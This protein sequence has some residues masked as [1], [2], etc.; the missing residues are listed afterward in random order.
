MG[1]ATPW[2]I[3]LCK[4][5]DDKRGFV[6]VDLQNTKDMFVGS[7]TENIAAYWQDVSYGSMDFSGS[8]AFGWL[9]LDKNQSDYVGSGR[10]PQG[11]QD[12]VTWARDAAKDAGYD[13][14]SFYGVAV[15]MS[16]AT[17]LWGGPNNV[18]CDLD[19]AMAAILQ[20]FGHGYGLAKHTRAVSTPTTDYT[21]PICVMS[22]M[23]FGGSDP[24][25]SGPFGASGPLLCSPYVDIAGWLAPNR[26]HA[27]PMAG[28]RPKLTTL[29]LS[30]LGERKPAFPQVARF[31][32]DRPYPAAY[33]VE[34]R[35]GGW[36]AGLPQALVAL[37]QR[38]PDGYC[39]YAGSI[40]ASNGFRDGKTLLPGRSWTDPDF[41][42]SVRLDRILDSGESVEITIGPRS[43]VQPLSVRQIAAAKLNL[44]GALSVRHQVLQAGDTS[45]EKRLLGLIDR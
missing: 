18:V 14:S 34:Y 2:A 38:R 19:S 30:P 32:F 5:K 11:R 22:A 28:Q 31:D 40:P 39:Y 4:F 35:F 12:L 36:D 37:H 9:T 43:A 3:L 26:I 6:T 42:L 10:D 15:F 41:D 21:N 17:D 44:R 29:R 25:Y 23:T 7:S 24:T 33:Y 16:T 20:E 45:L 1:P 8:K 13:L 27:I